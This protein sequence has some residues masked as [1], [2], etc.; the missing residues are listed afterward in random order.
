MMSET[1]SAMVITV[2]NSEG[3]ETKFK[4]VGHTKFKKIFNHY[5][6]S[7]GVEAKSLKFVFDGERVHPEQTPKELK[8]EDGDVIDVFIEQ[9]GGQ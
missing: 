7:K 3:D 8:M 1:K 2:R 4:I 5:G 6:K 9:E